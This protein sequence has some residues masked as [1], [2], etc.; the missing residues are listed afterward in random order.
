MTPSLVG[1]WHTRFVM[2]LTLGVAISVVFALIY[3]DSVFFFVLGYVL[4]FGFVWDVL[5]IWL[6][7]WRWD[8]D[9]PAAFQI[10][11]GLVEGVLIFLLIDGLGLPGIEAGSVPLELFVLHYGLVWLAIFLWVQGPMRVVAPHWRFRGGRL[12]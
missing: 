11:N 4:A 12:W 10:I 2:L 8:R 6:Q 1:R 9:W 5:Y 3:D 7:K